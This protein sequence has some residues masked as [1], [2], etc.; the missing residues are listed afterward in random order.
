MVN[1]INKSFDEFYHQMEKGVTF[2]QYKKGICYLEL[3]KFKEWKSKY[4]FSFNIFSN[5]HLIN[6]EAHFHFKHLGKNIDCKINFV[7]DILESKGEKDLDTKLIKYLKYFL[8]EQVIQDKLKKMWN[9]KNP[10][11]QIK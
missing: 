3:E 11:Y 10:S 9:D 1:N 8:S 2:E 7:G 6:N 5:D 4:N